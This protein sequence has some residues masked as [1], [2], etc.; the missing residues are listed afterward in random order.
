[1]IDIP[2][3]KTVNIIGYSKEK[4]LGFNAELQS[5]LVLEQNDFPNNNFEAFIPRTGEFVL[6]DISTPPPTYHLLHLQSDITLQLS[7]KTDLHI[8]LSITNILNTSYREYL[9][10]LRYFADDL[11]RNFMLQLK[12]KY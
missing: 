2:S 3:F 12:L 7:Q 9:N 11:G 1:M 4:W 6:V 8:G 5:E 10:R